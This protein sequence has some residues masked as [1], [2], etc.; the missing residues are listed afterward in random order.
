MRCLV[1]EERRGWRSAV[2]LG[3][4]TA[5]QEVTALRGGEE[6][7]SRRSRSR[8]SSRRSMSRSRRSRRRSRSM[9]SRSRRRRRMTTRSRRSIMR[10]RSKMRMS[11]TEGEKYIF[12]PNT[13][14]EHY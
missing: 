5:E 8:R 10:K 14:T 3:H 6:G 7:E 4:T 11:S 9:R 2:G 13:N 12:R 1:G